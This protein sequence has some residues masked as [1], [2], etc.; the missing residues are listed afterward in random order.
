MRVLSEI[1]TRI[2]AT[3]QAKSSKASI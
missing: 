1:A 3:G 2:P